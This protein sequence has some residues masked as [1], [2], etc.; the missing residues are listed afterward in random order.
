[1]LATHC[2]RRYAAQ[3]AGFPRAEL[4]MT[5]GDPSALEM[6]RASRHHAARRGHA[7]T[8]WLDHFLRASGDDA[9][10]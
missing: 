2:M 3:V 9:S 5:T 8:V 10:S 1:M 7:V 4:H 6:A